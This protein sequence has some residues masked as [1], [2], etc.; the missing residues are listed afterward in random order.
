MIIVDWTGAFSSTCDGML[1]YLKKSDVLML[2]H[3]QCC[4][5]ILTLIIRHKSSHHTHVNFYL[6]VANTA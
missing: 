1:K 5:S 4:G 3:Y 6:Q 2:Q